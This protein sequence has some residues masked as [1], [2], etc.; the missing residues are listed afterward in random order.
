MMPMPPAALALYLMKRSAMTELVSLVV[1]LDVAV[2]KVITI[3]LDCHRSR[4]TS[5]ARRTM[6][7]I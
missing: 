6:I 3:V 5:V 4:W 1:V 2:V 7:A